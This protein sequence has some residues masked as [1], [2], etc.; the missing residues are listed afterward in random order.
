[1]STLSS[2]GV[3]LLL[4]AT[5]LLG[6]TAGAQAQ[7][8]VS[9]CV[10]PNWPPYD[11]LR[12]G[13][14]IGI[15]AEYMRV[16]AEI[17]GLS[18]ELVPTSSWSQSLEYVQSGQCMMV[19]MLNKSPSRDQFLAFSDTYFEAPNV[20]VTRDDT[21]NL[22]GYEGIGDRLVGVVKGYRHAEYLMRYYPKIRLH[23][24]ESEADGLLKLAAEEIDVMVG[25]LFSVNHLVT[26]LRLKDLVIAGYA[27]P[28][29]ALSFGVNRAYADELIPTLNA[30]IEAIP[31]AQRVTIHRRW[32]NIKIHNTH[33]YWLLT[34]LL[35]LAVLSI[36]FVVWRRRVIGRYEKQLVAKRNE[37]D[38][39]KTTLLERNRTLEFLSSHDSITGLYNRNQMIQ[40]AEEEISR[41]Q[42]FQTSASL[43]VVELDS[44]AGSNFSRNEPFAEELLKSVAG[45][46]LT[47]V[48]EVDV[49]ARF[50]GDQ[51]VIMCPQ[52]DIVAAKV[53]ADRLI[54]AIGTSHL[55]RK[56]HIEVAVGLSA[57][58]AKER[59][60]D[61]Y[62]RTCK[63]L[64]Q[65]KRQG[66]GVSCIA[67]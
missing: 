54:D 27:E 24:V 37:I 41:F 34:A 1:M 6:A 19:S 22:Q 8:K 49:V 5:L 67:D 31:E 10:D 12:N 66:Y 36:I 32:N 3:R 13:E 7:Q 48:R 4:T 11:S 61:W 64:Y 9:Y 40:R 46:C 29:D 58:A 60:P 42:R 28:Y 63:A 23:P 44:D 51:F 57:L 17:S 65:S 30:A 21:P 2:L 14:H 35:T 47:T 50:G 55:A 45:M 16:V 56:D 26:K 39:L 25:S 43:I 38:A 20:L 52:T 59:F 33:N 53:L 18:F 62:E 15:A